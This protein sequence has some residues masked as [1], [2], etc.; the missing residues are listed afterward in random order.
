MQALMSLA[1]LAFF[2]MVILRIRDSRE[3][4]RREDYFRRTQ[5][6]LAHREKQLQMQEARTREAEERL[7]RIAAESIEGKS[8]QD[9]LNNTLSSNHRK[10]KGNASFLPPGIQLTPEM[11]MALAALD[12]GENLFVQGFAGT[13][14]STFIHIVRRYMRAKQRD[15]AIVAPSG[16]AAINAG[17]QTIHSFFWFNPNVPVSTEEIIRPPWG[18]RAEMF[19]KLSLLVIDEISMVRADLFDT[20]GAFLG[21][22]CRYSGIEMPF[23]DV[24]LCLVGDMCQL[25]PVL[26]ND[27]RRF[28][29]RYYESGDKRNVIHAHSFP[30]L[31]ANVLEFTYNFR[32]NE[33]HFMKLLSRIRQ[34]E[35][36]PD[37]I[38]ELNTRTLSARGIVGRPED[39]LVLT[40]NNN[41]ADGLNDARLNELPGAS[42]AYDA[43]VNDKKLKPKD[44]PA[45]AK[46]TL[47]VG[48]QVM[49][50]KNDK[51]HRWV[52]GMLGRVVELSDETVT[53]TAESGSILQVG[54]TEWERNEHV[55][56]P[57]TDA[58]ISKPVGWFRQ[59]PL[60]LAWA[61]TI[62]KAQGLTLSRVLVDLDAGTFDVGQFY[63]AVSRCRTWD[64][65]YFQRAVKP[66]DIK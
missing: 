57:R 41:K 1:I 66:S 42:Q 49:F 43:V 20:I 56:D 47:K 51:Q 54:R 36:S 62:H 31:K 26:E 61:V 52:N 29:E 27:D 4:K 25:P 9:I 45:P 14:K 46:L 30:A 63:V 33:E 19:R 40:P 2:V 32:Q 23:G 64:G 50:I 22:Y 59:I 16:I 60:R 21:K 17:G 34:G 53:V 11:E 35:R 5:D 38:N 15:M 18:N 24:Q 7:K 65:L 13:G 37:V 6:G 8:V 44:Y 39:C 48:A 3:R 58:I 55:Y 10:S 12:R 28:F